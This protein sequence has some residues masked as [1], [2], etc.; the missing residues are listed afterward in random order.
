MLKFC[1]WGPSGLFFLNIFDLLLVESMNAETMD[2]EVSCICLYE[3]YIG[4]LLTLK[5]SFSLN[6]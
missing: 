3:K 2:M 1:F 5:C 4:H 6:K